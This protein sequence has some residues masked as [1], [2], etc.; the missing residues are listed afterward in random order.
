MK[1]S[2]DEYE[3]N[4]S[5]DKTLRR[6]ASVFERKTNTKKAVTTVMITTYGLVRN[7]Y[8]DDNPY[9]GHDDSYF[10]ET[11]YQNDYGPDSADSETDHD[12]DATDSASESDAAPS[13]KPA[14][15]DEELKAV[16]ITV[17][18]RPGSA[19]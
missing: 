19:N 11:G 18:P 16:K 5:Y 9:P 14:P 15:T 12:A 13:A 10:D 6:K 7:S 2:K 1:F 8:S 4:A 3:I 17:S